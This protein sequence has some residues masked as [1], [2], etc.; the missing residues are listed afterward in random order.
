MKKISLF[1]VCLFGILYAQAGPYYTAGNQLNKLLESVGMTARVIAD[2]NDHSSSGA[3]ATWGA[4]FGTTNA[5]VVSDPSYGWHWQEKSWPT[6]P[7]RGYGSD[8]FEY[9]IGI[10]W[11]NGNGNGVSK[12]KYHQTA[13]LVLTHA[14][15]ERDELRLLSTF[16]LSGNEFY[17]FSL[18]G[19]NTAW[20]AAALSINLSNNLIGSTGLCTWK[21]IIVKNFQAPAIVTVNISNNCMSF[22]DIKQIVSLQAGVKVIY[23]PQT[24]N[25]TALFP[26]VDMS[27]DVYSASTVAKFYYNS[28]LLTAGT[29]YTANGDGTFTFTSTYSNKLI[30]CELTDATFATWDSRFDFSTNSIK[31]NITLVDGDPSELASVSVAAASS[32]IFVAEPVQLTATALNY[33]GTAADNTTFLWSCTPSTAGSFDDPTSAT[34]K[35]T[36]SSNGS[37]ALKCT[38]T[39]DAIVKDNTASISVTA[40]TSLSLGFTY[41]GYTLSEKVTVP[42][43]ANGSVVTRAG[44]LN[45]L[46]LDTDMAIEAGSLVY[47]PTTVGSKSLTVSLGSVTST[48]KA[49]TATHAFIPQNQLTATASS[50]EGVKDG[51]KT[52][53][54]NLAVDGLNDTRWAAAQAGLVTS[55]LAQEAYLLIELGDFYEVEM[56]EI[57]WEASKAAIYDVLVSTEENGVYTKIGG[58]TGITGNTNHYFIRTV[59]NPVVAKSKFVK[60]LCKERTNNNWNYSI[61]EVKVAGKLF[62]TVDENPEEL[63]SLTIIPSSLDMF[64]GEPIKVLANALNKNSDPA[65]GLTYAWSCTPS[66]AGSFDDATAVNPT[67]TPAIA[68][69]IKIECVAT[70]DAIVKDDE[71]TITPATLY[72]LALI[73]PEFYNDL[74]VQ[75]ESLAFPVHA[76]GLVITRPTFLNALVLDGD[77]TIQ[78]VNSD[79]S[80]LVYSPSTTGNKSLTIAFGSASTTQYVTVIPDNLIS[81]GGMTVIDCSSYDGTHTG[82]KIIDGKD[83]VDDGRWTSAGTTNE[84]VTVDLGADYDLSMLQINWETASASEYDIYTGMTS[85]T[86][87]YLTGQTGVS[88][89]PVKTRVDCLTEKARYLKI[90]CKQRSTSFAYSIYEIYVYGQPAP[91]AI[92][93]VS[94]KANVINTEYYNL[95]GVKVMQPADQGVYIVKRTLDNGNINMSKEIK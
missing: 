25:K 81:R 15:A 38:A 40:L 56:I 76:N 13:N 27:A 93:S 51:G 21:N 53:P 57:E 14:N 19:G 41:P 11:S 7:A 58:E 37:V 64:V 61:F 73:L 84:Y 39:Q 49:L 28:A 12:A 43:S 68:S 31:Y 80:K 33:N 34:P 42:V 89:G 77:M 36:P 71:I 95:Q 69:N 32:N 52:G 55:N 88:R 59:A 2:N 8:N 79:N 75:S 67:F 65:T 47:A 60:I 6:S 4:W 9:L 18:D 29:D 10:D 86:L 92:N 50:S 82:D 62:E 17:H 63:A 94:A 24:I 35:F 74:F 20:A 90:L 85:T 22:A 72:S 23:T 46:T 78:A 66:T 3:V 1:I 87:T 44:F 48:P 26:T 83:G 91:D 54:A 70:Q 30:T 45:A 16:D 5:S